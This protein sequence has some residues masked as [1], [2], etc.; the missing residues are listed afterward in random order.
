MII[1][2]LLSPGQKK[3][4]KIKRIYTAIKE[5]VMLVLLFTLIIAILLLIS[6]YVLDNQLA[7]LIEKNALTIQENQAIINEISSLN[8][9]IEI[10][11]RLQKDFK[12]WSDFLMAFSNIT[13]PNISYNLIKI[14]YENASIELRGVAKNRDD[15]IKLKDN[16]NNFN[17]LL[18]V[19][20]PLKNLLAKENN[21]FIITANLALDKI[22]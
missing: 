8:F 10:V 9:K 15:L 2:N 18:N 13:P 16:L 20:L 1:I 17:L 11:S 22:R 14:Q 5:L 4:L 6:K 7:K 12:K 21:E 19:N 3:D